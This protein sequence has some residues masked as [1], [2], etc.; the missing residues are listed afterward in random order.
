MQHVADVGGLENLGMNK[1]E[2]GEDDYNT[3]VGDRIKNEML[4]YV[5]P[6]FLGGAL[7]GGALKAPQLAT[8]TI[9][10][11]KSLKDAR[12]ERKNRF[13]DFNVGTEEYDITDKM[14]Q[15]IKSQEEPN[16]EVF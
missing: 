9:K 8:S 11:G 6:D 12:Q 4:N 1:N 7:F 15:Y 14:K 16:G 3:P 10:T 2:E 13:K 5:L